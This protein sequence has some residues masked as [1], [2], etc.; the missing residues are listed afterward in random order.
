MFQMLKVI[1]KV[2]IVLNG[3]HVLK[4]K[5]NFKFETVLKFKY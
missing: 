1:M 5:K 2:N 3:L 4:L